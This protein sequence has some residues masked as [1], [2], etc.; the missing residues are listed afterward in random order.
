MPHCPLCRLRHRLESIQNGGEIHVNRSTP[1]VR[2]VACAALIALATPAVLPAATPLPPALDA[3]HQYPSSATT[4]AMP[5]ALR[6]AVE[7]SLARDPDATWIEHEIV[8]A[9]GQA[10]DLFGFRV[11]VS[12]DIAFVSA[13]A[14]GPRPGKVYVFS[15]SS[16]TWT[17]TQ[18]LTATP[19][20][21]PP[22]NWSDFFGW[23]LSLSGDSLLV[24][25]PEVFNQM[26]GPVGG[27]YV[28]VRSGDTW[29]QQQEL[30]PA[31]GFNFDWV[32]G[33]VALAG[34]TA[35]VGAPNH[36]ATRGEVHV[37]TRS[38]TTWT[39][40]TPLLASDGA[41]GDAHQFGG[42]VKFD[43]TTL[44]IGAPGP[45]FSSSDYSPGEAYVFTNQGGTWTEAQ[46]L[47]PDDG[48]DGDQFGFSLAIQGT[49]LLIG[50]P[51]ADIG[52]NTHQGA[53]YVF[54]GSGGTFV[55][56]HKIF[57]DDGVAYDQFGQSV[58][59]SGDTAL[60]GMWS[61]NDDPNTPPATPK[62]GSV[63]L[64]SAARDSWTQSDKLTAS[65]ATDGDSFG[66]DVGV[67]GTT[68]IVGAQGTVGGN[69]FQGAAY[70]YT[71]GDPPV[72][73]VTP[74]SLSFSLA[75]GASG[76]S[77]ITIGNTGGSDLTFA[78]AEAA[79]NAPRVALNLRPASAPTPRTPSAIGTSRIAGSRTAAP[80]APR[81]PDG[82]LTFVLDD[83]T[84]ED[85]IGL[86]DQTSTES[87]AIWL[88]R[89]SPP[90]GT[91]AFTID[92]ISIL[93][94]QNGNGT[95]VGKA[96]NLVAYYDADGDG[97]PTN[98]VRLGSD[99][100]ITID[101]LDA[102]IDYTVNFAVPGDG[103]VY[104]G[105]ENVYALGGSSPIL[106]P[107]AIDEDS[108]TQDRSWV[109]G[110]SSGDPDPDVL[111]NNDLLGTIDS[112]GLP[113]NWLIR[114]T[115][116]AGGGGGDCSNPSDVPWLSESPT[117]GTVA[118]GG[119]Q[120]VTVTADA[121]GLDPG[122]YSALVC[123]STND[124]NNALVGVSVSLTVTADDTIFKDGFDG[125]P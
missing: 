55:Q 94:P 18:Q 8:A 10:F 16:G 50:T 32:G 83:G 78:I 58:A 109:A 111:G 3:A 40:G 99:D 118:V 85:T 54:D 20:V 97:D 79:A 104:I 87:A 88:N 57:A 62:P 114:A 41:Q 74:D 33:A 96:I 112:F 39:E 56:T 77:P 15:N 115:G 75:P 24:G 46:I 122:T 105:F 25:A 73:T 61:H 52:A 23:S 4:S 29:S 93:W 100:M 12:G 106:F 63:Y 86:N 14:P 125:A 38:G 110:M 19:S 28:F 9:D 76:S 81:S 51:A 1:S 27:A 7:R 26:F 89:F 71:P 49:T 119:S 120:D 6:S 35:F 90:A 65:D 5:P 70:V 95:L 108:G 72:A 69:Q 42:A 124:P 98:A 66:W 36:D 48:A 43:G 13:P 64:F 22:P 17:E 123:V 68:L 116:V 103:D 59:M 37:Y 102:F 34:D 60:I 101:S 53:A 67:D 44:L 91:G 80:W 82:A 121:T 117:S 2:A 107:A 11:L 84:Y 45:D 21:T 92:S 31:D 113:G 30:L 47:Q